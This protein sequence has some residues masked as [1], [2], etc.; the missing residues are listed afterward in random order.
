[1]A[2]DF[3]IGKVFITGYHDTK[4]RDVQFHPFEFKSLSKGCHKEQ[5]EKG[6]HHVAPLTYSHALRDLVNLVFNHQHTCIVG[7]SMAGMFQA[8][9]AQKTRKRDI[10]R[11]FFWCHIILQIFKEI[12]GKET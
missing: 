11:V 2:A 7:V 12:I 4:D 5:E 8:W 6:G 10:L 9:V 3:S 1:M